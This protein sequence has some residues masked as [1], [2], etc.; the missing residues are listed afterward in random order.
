[1]SPQS[2]TEAHLRDGPAR[3]VDDCKDNIQPKC[4]KLTRRRRRLRIPALSL[5]ATLLFFFGP[6]IAFTFGDRADLIANRL[7]AGMPSLNSGW[8]VIRGFTA[9]AVDHLP[10]RSQA[11]RA[12][13]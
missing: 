13:T 8:Q 11:V 4:E 5:A 3:E 10:L 1:M 12:D 2:P 7:L 9:W 6:A